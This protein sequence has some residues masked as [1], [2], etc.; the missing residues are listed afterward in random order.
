VQGTLLVT[1]MLQLLFGEALSRLFAR[2]ASPFLFALSCFALAFGVGH[3]VL[4]TVLFPISLS[5]RVQ[6][7]Q[8]WAVLVVA[9]ALACAYALALSAR[10]L[11]VDVRGA[12]AALRDTGAF[13]AEAGRTVLRVKDLLRTGKLPQAS[14][15][16]GP[17]GTGAEAGAGGGD[18]IAGGAEDALQ[19]D[20]LGLDDGVGPM[21]D[22][23]GQVRDIRALSSWPLVAC[24]QLSCETFAAW[25]RLYGA[26]SPR[27]KFM[28]V[29]Q[30]Q[31][32]WRARRASRRL[33]LAT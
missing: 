29:R 5:G 33:A 19:L 30:C 23:I 16:V 20:G 6:R 26:R 17:A 15:F 27:R 2:D 10:W 28:F 9:L 18:A 8:A 32:R 4:P 13:W 25:L 21:E 1:L 31:T 12:A 22:G 14:E 3:A 24:R 11:D 7:T